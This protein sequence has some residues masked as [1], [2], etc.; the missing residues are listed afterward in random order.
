MIG[1]NRVHANFSV[2]DLATAKSFYVDKLG[3][4]VLKETPMG[5]T[6]EGGEGTCVNIYEKE[7]HQPWNATVLGI[8]VDDVHGAVSELK[9]KGVTMEK[10]DGTDDDGVMSDP[11]MGDAAWFKDPANN[12]VC[13][14]NINR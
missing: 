7:D 13:V 6:L 12:W 10:L 11:Q 3:L 8:E 14:S 1:Q 5:I 2:D 9:E 4:K